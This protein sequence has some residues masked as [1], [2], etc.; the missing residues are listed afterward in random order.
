LQPTL[1]IR[2]E[3]PARGGLEIRE[4]TEI[5]DPFAGL[6]S[7]LSNFKRRAKPAHQLQREGT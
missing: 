5:C 7:V 1:P 6:A 3:F 2:R 4:T